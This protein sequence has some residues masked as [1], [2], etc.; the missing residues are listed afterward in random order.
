MRYL[1]GVI[2]AQVGFMLLVAGYRDAYPAA[3]WESLLGALFLGAG[4]QL[5]WSG[6][7]QEQARG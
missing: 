3:N 4:V 1:Y 5:A 2:V 6:F 7:K